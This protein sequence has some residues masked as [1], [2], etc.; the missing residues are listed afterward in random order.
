MKNMTDKKVLIREFTLKNPNLS[1]NEILTI[2]KAKGF[3]IRKTDFLKEVRDVRSLPDPSIAKKEVSTPIK[4]RTIIQKERITKRQKTKEIKEAK[5]K[6]KE[7]KEAKV[8]AK[9]IKEAKVKAKEIKEAKEKPVKIP[10]EETKFGKMA[11][12]V[13]NRHRI[14]EKNAI[15]RTRKLLK[16]PK[17]DYDK[18]NE[19][20]YDILTQYGY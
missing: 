19:I 14:S 18:L 12:D 7:I 5:V 15:R 8:K 1:A 3:S 16:L 10:Y 11:K 4:Y 9:E 20:D 2:A 6:A 13:Q 17:I